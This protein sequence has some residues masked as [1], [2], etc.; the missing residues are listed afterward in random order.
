MPD[1]SWSRPP[2][3]ARPREGAWWRAQA[4][5]ARRFLRD[6]L[7]AIAPGPLLKT[8]V[9]DEASGPHHPLG[10]APP[11]VRLVGMDID[12]AVAGL[13]RARL[14]AEGRQV[15]VVVADVGQLPFAAGAFAAVLSLSTLDHLSS[16]R[17]IR[18]ALAECFRVLRPGGRLLLTLDNPWNPEVALRWALPP[19][20]VSRLRADTF[21]LGVTLGRRRGRRALEETGFVV[22]TE[23][24]LVHVPRYPAIRILAWL[25]RRGRADRAER[26]VGRLEALARW[27][28]R[29]FTGHYVAWVAKKPGA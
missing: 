23:S 13:A 4:G 12:R 5:V 7:P 8:D 9:F 19:A 25:D 11:G 17:E 20:I 18:A 22:Q 2:L 16:E 26:L 29:A 3:A 10:D 27:P 21:P 1:R 24:Y 6:S 14:S 28:S 15:A